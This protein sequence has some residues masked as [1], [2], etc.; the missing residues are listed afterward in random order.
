MRSRRPPF[1]H[2]ECENLDDL[3]VMHGE[4]YCVAKAVLLARAFIGDKHLLA[5]FDDVNDLK[6]FS[7]CTVWPADC[8]IAFAAKPVVERASEAKSS[9]ISASN[10]G[11]S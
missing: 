5:V 1:A 11:P 6:A 9:A 10:A 8:E 7:G 3:L 4:D 2:K